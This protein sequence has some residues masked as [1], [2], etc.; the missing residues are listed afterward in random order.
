MTTN[1]DIQKM[2][3]RTLLASL[4]L[5]IASGGLAD[6]AAPPEDRASVPVAA[7]DQKKLLNGYRR[8]QGTCGHCHGPDGVGGSFAPSLIESVL[9]FAEFRTVVEEGSRTGTSVMLGF[10]GDPNVID[11]I[12][13][14][15]AYLLARA[16]GAIG[17]GRPVF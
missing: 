5:L 17:R 13:D 2:A 4:F 11:H 16:D 15:Y 6:E 9:P 14:I 8:Y 1:A 3:Y 10:A 12:D 7:V